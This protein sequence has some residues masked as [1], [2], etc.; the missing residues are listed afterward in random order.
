MQPKP[1]GVTAIIAGVLAVLGGLFAVFGVIAGVI[2]IVSLGFVHWLFIL[3]LVEDAIL[4]GTLL[5]GGILLF[6]RKPMGRI[7]TIVGSAFAILNAVVTVVLNVVGF[8]SFSPGLVAAGSILG[9]LLAVLPAGTT[10]VL[11]IVKPTAVWC[12]GS[13]R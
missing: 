3:A 9:L 8:G 6:L 1:S 7:L 11:A 12:G 5:P 4:V 2:G 13:A 10:L